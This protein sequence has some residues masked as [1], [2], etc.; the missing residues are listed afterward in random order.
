M[1]IDPELPW[2]NWHRIEGRS[3]GSVFVDDA[4]GETWPSLRAA[5]WC[6]RL[7]MPTQNGEPPAELLELVHAVLAA[8]VRREPGYRQQLADLFEGNRLF[9]RMF[10]LWLASTG[11]AVLARNGEGVGELTPEGWS[12]LLMLAATRPYDVRRNRPCAATIAM[13]RELGLG[14]EDREVRLERLEREARRWD[15]AFLR[16]DEAGR[17]TIV[18][19]KRSD[20]PVPILQTVWTL[21]FSTRNQRDGFYDWLCR[22]LDRWQ[23]WGDLASQ[24]DSTKLTHK[25]L[26][27]MTEWIAE[28]DHQAPFVTWPRRNETS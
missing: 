25:L 28:R 21:G 17:P 4:T 13:L 12:V 26:A 6:G 8:T 24:Y 23:A 14:P 3:S 5:L 7:G 9:Q 16:C 22:H 20:G 15:A 2:G 11:L 10:H 27:V 19:A 18:L 1:D